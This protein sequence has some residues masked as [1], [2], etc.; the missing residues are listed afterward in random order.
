MPYKRFVESDW[1]RSILRTATK[2]RGK[3]TKKHN[4]RA[5]MVLWR[6]WL[7]SGFGHSKPLASTEVQDVQILDKKQ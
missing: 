5:K 2:F 3:S 7:L 1:P 6:I 4:P